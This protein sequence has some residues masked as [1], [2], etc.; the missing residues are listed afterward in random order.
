MLF[1][2]INQQYRS[3]SIRSQIDYEESL[4]GNMNESPKIFHRYVRQKEVG[5]PSVGPHKKLNGSISTH[6]AEMSE[7][8]ASEY[9][10]VYIA[11]ELEHPA[12]HQRFHGRFDMDE[13][14]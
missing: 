2:T 11:N 8:L 3:F 13:I 12:L 14:S 6:P 10:S 7:V 4:A 5:Y 9:S 1:T